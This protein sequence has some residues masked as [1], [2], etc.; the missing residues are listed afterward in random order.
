M[1]ATAADA[2]LRA[3]MRVA[4]TN[5]RPQPAEDLAFG[6]GKCERL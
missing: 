5:G 3:L 1:N 6:L 2:S 4:D